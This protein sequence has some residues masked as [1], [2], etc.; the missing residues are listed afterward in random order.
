MLAGSRLFFNTLSGLPVPEVL[1]L[2]KEGVGG[3]K[4]RNGKKNWRCK[5]KRK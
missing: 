4:K 1:L 3:V 2:K 5:R